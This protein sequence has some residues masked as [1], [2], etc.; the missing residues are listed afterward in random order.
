MLAILDPAFMLRATLML[1]IG[2]PVFVAGQVFVEKRYPQR[3]PLWTLVMLLPMALTLL[4]SLSVGA[5]A[6]AFIAYAL[7]PQNLTA[8]LAGAMIGMFACAWS[9]AILNQVLCNLLRARL[10]LKQQKLEL[11]R[12]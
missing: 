8:V 1:V 7:V 6:G 5:A 10:G 2:L 9:I 11:W 3:A 12:K 4:A